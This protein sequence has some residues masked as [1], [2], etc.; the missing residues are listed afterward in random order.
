MIDVKFLCGHSMKMGRNATS[1][2]C[3]CNLPGCNQIAS[4]KAPAPSFTGTVLGPVS[5]FQNLPATDVSAYMSGT[6]KEQSHG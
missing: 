5:E 2:R 6:E 4:M 3:F 1:A